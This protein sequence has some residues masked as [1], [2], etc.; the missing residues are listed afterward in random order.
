[1]E[2]AGPTTLSPEV[3]GAI[4]ARAALLRQA[5]LVGLDG[6]AA[7]PASGDR[8]G[9]PVAT[10]C[11]IERRAVGRVAGARRQGWGQQPFVLAVN[12]AM[13]QALQGARGRRVQG[14]DALLAAA[15][16]ALTIAAE[17]YGPDYQM[18]MAAVLNL[19][20]CVEERPDIQ[21][22]ERVDLILHVARWRAE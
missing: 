3:V 16:R 19:G 1:M 2:L 7:F 20:V 21:L 10:G 22:C 17:A 8:L 6:A 14:D 18:T 4:D 15:R 12:L 13:T 5:S 9:T 11:L